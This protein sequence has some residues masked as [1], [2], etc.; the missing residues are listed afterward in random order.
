MI[1]LAS[2]FISIFL[3]SCGYDDSVG[4]LADDIEKANEVNEKMN[5]ENEENE[6]TLDNQ[7]DTKIKRTVENSTQQISLV[8]SDLNLN[9][10][11]DW[12]IEGDFQVSV[13]VDENNLKLIAYFD[14]SHCNSAKINYDDLIV[15]GGICSNNSHFT[16]FHERDLKRVT[17]IMIERK[18][19]QL[20]YKALTGDKWKILAYISLKENWQN[21]VE[22]CLE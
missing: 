20:S 12:S 1:R 19:D 13:P 16:L 11:T 9:N 8:E 5:E 21:S 17:S 4:R 10:C 15:F 22:F 2:T 7:Q 14:N 6:E 3:I 18:A